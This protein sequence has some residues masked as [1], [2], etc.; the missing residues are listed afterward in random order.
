MGEYGRAATGE[1]GKLKP[2][3]EIHLVRENLTLALSLWRA[4]RNR[5]INP[6]LLLGDA[7]DA[8]HNDTGRSEASLNRE[9][10]EL[11]TRFGANQVRASFALSVLQ[12]QR[13][14]ESVFSGDPLDEESPDLQSAR[15]CVF[16]MDAAIGRDMF[17]PVWDCPPR[18]RRLFEVRPVRFVL[19]AGDIHATLVNWDHFGGLDK[20]LNLLDYC[21]DWAART[22][23]GVQGPL[24]LT[25]DASTNE[26]YR[27]PP[28]SSAVETA[29]E[30]GIITELPQERVAGEAADGVR[31]FLDTCCEVGDEYRSPAKDLYACYLEWCNETG[32]AAAPQRSFGMCLSGMGLQ[33]R[34]R[35]RGKHWWEGVRLAA[36][37]LSMAGS[38][39]EA[40]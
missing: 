2:A 24:T 20:Y 11:L 26:P 13:S 33:R 6:D 32:R 34:R 17:S 27:E 22:Q 1:V 37:Q 31:L 16:L 15:C 7:P 8:V 25:G 14:L 29:P 38:R 28:S 39:V 5:L 4:A 9:R 36:A 23:F 19:D 3:Q 35:G 40:H 12:T 30:T 10:A 18:Y 21:A